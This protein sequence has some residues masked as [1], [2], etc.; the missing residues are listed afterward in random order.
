[1][2]VVIINS[3]SEC[4][5]LFSGF[6]IKKNHVCRSVFILDS[7]SIFH[8]IRFKGDVLSQFQFEPDAEIGQKGAF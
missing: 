1:M 6:A 2:S 3:T 5:E 4:Q 8:Y 7:L